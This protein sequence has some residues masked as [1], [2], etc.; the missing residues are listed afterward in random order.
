MSDDYKDT[1]PSTDTESPTE[2]KAPSLSPS[3]DVGQRSMQG[4]DSHEQVIARPDRDFVDGAGRNITLRTF[5]NGDSQ[6]IRAYDR[7][8]KTPPDRADRGQAGLANVLLEDHNGQHRARLQ[9]IEV[10]EKYQGKG[11]GGEL[12]QEAETVA[13]ERRCSEIYGLAP[14]DKETQTWYTKRGF[15]FRGREGGG[16]E[17]Y[18]QLSV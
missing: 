6:Y 8:E 15:Q 4:T 7:A 3:S 18:K 14:D 17:V 16:A 12:L 5:D 9:D 13:K 2:M 1:K 11:I 10:P